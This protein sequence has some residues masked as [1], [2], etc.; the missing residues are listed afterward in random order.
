MNKQRADLGFG[1]AGDDLNLEEFA[2]KPRTAND[3]PPPAVTEKAASAAGFRSR[4]PKAAAPKAAAA[5]SAR[6]GEGGAL[7]RRRRTGRNAQFNLKARQDTIDEFK[8]LSDGQGLGLGEGLEW[9]V[10]LMRAA[11]A[12]GKA[13][14]K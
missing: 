12:D 7:L 3:R 6:E 10:S 11:I 8:A 4:E 1:D 2:P 5:E 9:A 13:P 14:V